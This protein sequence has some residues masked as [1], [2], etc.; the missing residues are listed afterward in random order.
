MTEYV[1]GEGLL[2]TLSPLFKVT[3]AEAKH[4]NTC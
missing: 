2:A 3:F 1:S 4:F